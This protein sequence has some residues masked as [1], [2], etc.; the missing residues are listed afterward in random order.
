MRAPAFWHLPEPDAAAMALS[1]I[2]LIWGAL[3]ARRMKQPGQ[4]ASVPVICIGNFLAG[5]AGKTPTALACATLLR[6]KGLRPV[7]LSRGYGGS[8]SRS[9]EPLRIDPFAHD[10][11]VAGDEALLLARSAPTIVSADRVRGAARAAALGDVIVMDDGLQNPSLAKD[12]SVAVVDGETGVGN[13]LCIPAGPLRAP[14]EA[15]FSHVDAVIVIGPGEAG[16]R[17][18][19]R[20][21]ARGL[22]VF[23]ATLMPDATAAARLAGQKVVA[24][25][26]IGRPEKF[27]ATLEQAGADVCDA[28]S[29]GDHQMLDAANLASLRAAARR[30]NARL[31]TT[32]KDLA[33]LTGAF[34]CDDI[35]VLPVTLAIADEATFVATL[36]DKI[37]R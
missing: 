4:T 17:L 22:P 14:L 10:A 35:D 27:F 7:F 26:G 25:A 36:Q 15:Q 8:A 13:G 18:A 11:K 1:P 32:E 23:R 28:Y 3:S 19:G 6:A 2:G 20:A 37:G 34:E 21:S 33:R 24:F 12:F 5:G 31:V 16:D 9:G 30:L 29:F